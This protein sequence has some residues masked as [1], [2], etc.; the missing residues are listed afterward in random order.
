M[1][2]H[3]HSALSRLL[4]SA[5]FLALASLAL[6]ACQGVK[7]WERGRL[8]HPCMQSPVDTVEHA[9]HGHVESVREGSTGGAAA[10]GGGCGCN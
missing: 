5:L 9:Y 10:A 6:S 7:P 1:P 3:H 2:H 4:I 8:A